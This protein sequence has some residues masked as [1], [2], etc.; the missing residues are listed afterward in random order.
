[1]PGTAFFCPAFPGKLDL[2]KQITKGPDDCEPHFPAMAGASETH[3]ACLTNGQAKKGVSMKKL[4]SYLAVI[5]LI[6]TLSGPFFVQASGSMASAATHRAGSAVA[7][8]YRGPCPVPS[9]LDC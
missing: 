3:I 9:E 8:L 7:F 6:A 1:M 5:A 2:S 4:R